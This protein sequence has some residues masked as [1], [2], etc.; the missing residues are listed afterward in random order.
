[1]FLNNTASLGGAA[2]VSGNATIQN[3][4]FE[5]NEAIYFGGALFLSCVEEKCQSHLENTFFIQNKAQIFSGG[6]L[7]WLYIKPTNET[8]TFT[9]N[10]A[11]SGADHASLGNKA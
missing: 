9:E 8:I 5:Q 1:M 11:S 10:V 7:F 3:T 6:G 4:H 2:F